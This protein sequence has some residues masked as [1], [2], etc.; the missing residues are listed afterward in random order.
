MRTELPLKTIAA[1]ALLMCAGAVKL[2]EDPPPFAPAK[3]GDVT[4]TITPPQKI[5]RL[6]C[7]SRTTGKEYLPKSCDA[8]TG[9]FVFKDLPGDATYDICFDTP[10]GRRI[11]GIDLEFVDARLLR[12]A[13]KR[14]KQLGVPTEP[15]RRFSTRDVQELTG[16][17]R[18]LKDFMEIRRILYIRGGGRR[19]TM[20]VEL[21]RARDFHARKGDEIIWRIELWYFENQYGGWERLPNQ[22]RILQRRRLT[23]PQ[24]RE[25]S[26][27][28]YPELSVYVHPDGSSAPVKF[29]VPTKPDPSRSRP[30]NTPINIKTTPHIIGLDTKPQPS[31]Q[32]FHAPAKRDLTDN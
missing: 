7:I 26:I 4:G 17:V 8:K 25:I 13:A 15:K 18:D 10:G 21:I 31:S 19:A 12:L 22:E 24:W 28:Y 9:R 3:S 32:P 14:R 6:R 29:K 23:Y 5:S 16:Y 1:I 2:R 20:L 30:A 27:E 11:E